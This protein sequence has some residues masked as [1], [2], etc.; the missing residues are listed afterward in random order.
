MDAVHAH[1]PKPHD[2]YADLIPPQGIKLTPRHYAYLKISEGCNHRC[3]FCIIPSMRGDLVSR[4][5]GDVM[6][7][8]QHLVNAG[9]KELLVISQDT[10]A[11][12]VDIKYRTGFWGGRPLKT[13]MTDLAQALAGLG[14][15]VRL[16]YVYPY[17][18]VDEVVPLMARGRLLPYLDVPFQHASPRL[19]KLMKRPADAENNLERIR[20]WRE[21]CPDITLRSTFIVGFPGETE[22]EFE[23]LLNFLEQA[24]L[25]RVGCFA[26][27]PI[28]GAAANALPD[29]VAEEV[30]E[31]RRAR[32]MATQEKI[33]AAR[34]KAKVGRTLDVL[35]D[36]LDGDTAIARS[37]SD[38]PEI[39]GL[40]YVGG[41][42]R[43]KPGEFA[44]VRITRS[45]QHDL[46]GVSADQ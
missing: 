36:Q 9:V 27:S 33:S 15:W 7:E 35:V 38:A 41:G 31:E 17:P 20:R 16:H 11:Y 21:I 24:Q 23:Q 1:L 14:V 29:P 19:L 34:L 3:T 45:D 18:H 8:A 10:S 5:V 13:R 46:W 37:A 39:D 44:R 22:A 40:V 28:D 32:F 6:Q 4:P 43:L 2:P 26:Y 12:G 42:K 25:D 30:K